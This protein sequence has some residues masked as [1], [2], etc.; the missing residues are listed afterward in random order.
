MAGSRFE[1]V[2]LL[3]RHEGGRPL[4]DWLSVPGVPAG[5]KRSVV[6]SAA[7]RGAGASVVLHPFGAGASPPVVAKLALGSHS[8]PA[9]EEW[10]LA[11]LGPAAAR[12]GAVVPRPLRRIELDGEPVLVET[13]VEGRIL[14]PLL[15]RRPS[16]LRR[17]LTRLCEWLDAWQ[18]LSATTTPVVRQQLEREVLAP[19]RILAPHLEQGDAYVAALE[20]RCVA[21][22][23]SPASLV[24]SHNDL[25]MWNVLVDGRGHLGIV[26]WEGAE[27][28][29]L[30]LKDFFYAT[31]DAVAATERYADRLR[32]ARACF[33]PGG[34]HYGRMDNLCRSLA[35]SIGASPDIVELAFH[36]CWLGHATNE[37]RKVSNSDATPFRAIAQWLSRRELAEDRDLESGG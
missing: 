13:R 4:F 7:W 18:R 25:T 1:N 31:V 5:S 22:A 24:A 28:A 33:E 30:P 32:A 9:E 16:R 23:D 36:A 21:A 10:R 6:V 35:N 37:L 19:A 12:A 26:D 17:A 11:Q 15:G 27:K 2:A 29:T 14:A 3:A 34:A 8:A 20:V